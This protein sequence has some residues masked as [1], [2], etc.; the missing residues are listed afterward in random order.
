MAGLPASRVYTH[1]A[2]LVAKDKT[3]PV[4]LVLDANSITIHRVED[5]PSGDSVMASINLPYVHK[6]CRAAGRSRNPG[7]PAM[8]DLVILTQKGL[9]E[10]RVDLGSQDTVEL[11]PT[12]I[13]KLFETVLVHGSA[14]QAHNEHGCSLE[15][16]SA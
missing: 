3:Q 2:V 7:T 4:R 8:V 14:V 6:M 16:Q 1:K 15:G 9:R 10:L 5:K 13:E 11:T 12:N